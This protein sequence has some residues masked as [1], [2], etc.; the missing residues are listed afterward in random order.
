MRRNKRRRRKQ[1]KH[2]YSER[3]DM[4]IVKA[5]EMKGRDWRAVLTF[6]KQNCEIL[7]KDGELILPNM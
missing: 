5:V 3:E 4:I 2:K 1:T 7:G 6:M